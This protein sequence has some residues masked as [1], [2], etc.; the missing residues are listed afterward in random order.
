MWGARSTKELSKQLPTI[1]IGYSLK[2]FQRL[3]EHKSR[4]F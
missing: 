3:I 1:L 4:G 2:L